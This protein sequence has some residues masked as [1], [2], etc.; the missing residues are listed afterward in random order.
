MNIVKKIILGFSILAITILVVGIGGITGI[1]KIN[2]QLQVVSEDSIP[3][4]VGSYQ[5][6]LSLNNA[7]QALLQFLNSGAEDFQTHIDSFDQS[8]E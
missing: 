3:K 5:Q 4:L 6:I 8:Y 7:N 1:N 2:Q